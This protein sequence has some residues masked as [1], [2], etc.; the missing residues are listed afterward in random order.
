MAI[1]EDIVDQ[2]LQDWKR[3]RPEL[4]ASAMA[5]VGRI[6]LLGRLLE[7][8]VNDSLKSIGISYTELDV[9]A[10]LRRSGA[11]YRLSPTALRKSALLTSGAMTAC[12]NRLEVRGLITRSAEESDRRSLTAALTSKGVKLADK[13]IVVRFKQAEKAVAGLSSNEQNE[14]A[15]LLRKMRAAVK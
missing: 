2:L 1:K 8:D 13:A 14:L 3:E 5:V 4:D 15:R 12:L 9:L 7:T 10:T 11:P 6:L